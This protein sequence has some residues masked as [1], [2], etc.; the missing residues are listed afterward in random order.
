MEQTPDQEVT[1]MSITKEMM[2]TMTENS[3]HQ[4]L[5]IMLVM[6]AMDIHQA[7]LDGQD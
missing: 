2:L 3:H 1:M 6:V 4:I 5:F 7:L